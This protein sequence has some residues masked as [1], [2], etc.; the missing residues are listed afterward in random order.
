MVTTTHVSENFTHKECACPHC[1][2]I[3]SVAFVNLLQELREDYGKPIR[4][5]S[6]YRC[7]VHNR[8]IGGHRTSAHLLK[9]NQRKYGAVDIKLGQY[10]HRDRY[11]LVTLAL[12]LGFNNIEVANHHLH[13]GRV[14]KDHPQYNRIIWGVSK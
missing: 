14:P 1:D 12:K 13:L 11:R 4:V 9:H 6:M 5:S 8:K 10:Y 2:E 7:S 3:A